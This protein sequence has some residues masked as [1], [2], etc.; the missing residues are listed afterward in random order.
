MKLSKW[1]LVG[2]IAVAAM[3]SGTQNA[4]AFFPVRAG[5]FLTPNFAR[6]DVCNYDFN[7]PIRCRTTAWGM[8]PNGLWLNGWADMYLVPGACNSAFVY[9]NYPA[10][11][12]NANAE[13]VCDFAPWW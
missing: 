13:A 6:A 9:A 1:M 7:M 8:L 2:A 3:F 10:W 11:F 4:N 5:A 12:V